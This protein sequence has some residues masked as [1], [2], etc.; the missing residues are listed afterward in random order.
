DR[1]LDSLTE[2]LHLMREAGRPEPE[3]AAFIAEAVTALHDG[4]AA[5][6]LWMPLLREGLAL[7]PPDDEV[8]WARLTLLIERFE[9]YTINGISGSRW[10]GTDPRAAEIARSSGDED[11]FARSLQPWD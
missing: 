5:P 10:L 9:A 11:L 6:E 1:A 2:A 4:G 7:T 8:T 3:Q